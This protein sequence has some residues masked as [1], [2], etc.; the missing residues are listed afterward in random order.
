MV[1]GPEYPENISIGW[2]SS[3]L[4]N[5][6]LGL[7]VLPNHLLQNY[8]FVTMNG[9]LR[10]RLDKGNTLNHDIKPITFFSPGKLK[11]NKKNATRYDYIITDRKCNPPDRM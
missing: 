8:Y 4:L 2:C 1:F 6:E 5:F 10:I 9:S 7:R 11:E 3:G